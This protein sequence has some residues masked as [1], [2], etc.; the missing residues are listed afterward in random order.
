[1]PPK[2]RSWEEPWA[3]TVG[4]VSFQSGPPRLCGGGLCASAPDGSVLAY[5][6]GVANVVL[7]DVASGFVVSRFTCAPSIG[8]VRQLLWTRFGG[9]NDVVVVSDGKYIQTFRASLAGSDSSSDDDDFHMGESGVGAPCDAVC[10]L[11]QR[12]AC[13]AAIG[14][15]DFD[16]ARTSTLQLLVLVDSIDGAR[17]FSYDAKRHSLLPL[18]LR[19]TSSLSQSSNLFVCAE[20]KGVACAAHSNEAGVLAVGS[21]FAVTVAKLGYIQDVTTV[22]VSILRVCLLGAR[23][24]PLGIVSVCGISATRDA[25]RDASTTDSPVVELGGW[26]LFALPAE[27]TDRDE[28]IEGAKDGAGEDASALPG[29][30][31]GLLLG[32]LLLSNPRPSAVIAELS[33]S[34]AASGVAASFGDDD[35]DAKEDNLRSAMSVAALETCAAHGSLLSVPWNQVTGGG[36][37]AT[38]QAMVPLLGTLTST[39]VRLVCFSV[40][41]QEPAALG[42]KATAAVFH[43][44]A[45]V[46]LRACTD[47]VVSFEHQNVRGVPILAVSRARTSRSARA[48]DL[49]IGDG[50]RVVLFRHNGAYELLLST[51][52][53]PATNGATGCGTSLCLTLCGKAEWRLPVNTEDRS[54]SSS[55]TYLPWACVGASFLRSTSLKQRGSNVLDAVLAVLGGPMPPAPPKPASDAADKPLPGPSLVSLNTTVA[56]EACALFPISF[57]PVSQSAQG[58][59][60]RPEMRAASAMAVGARSTTTDGNPALS[61]ETKLW[62]ASIVNESQKALRRDLLETVEGLERRLMTRLGSLEQRL[63]EAVKGRPA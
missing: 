14:V 57:L 42:S 40:L 61:E 46:D 7:L 36:P 21:A 4:R 26:L 17:F 31:P 52:A 63:T 19:L 30:Q 37:R 27:A 48:E 8:T 24:S 47:E 23:V 25:T 53:R 51:C 6:D 34:D 20:L 45:P 10:L 43:G 58:V 44:P 56:L 18:S 12:H 15:S 5:C 41:R 3:R 22:S 11:E 35:N 9:A 54:S 62:L 33:S 28:A 13:V 29:S 60:H 59:A 55:S 38:L 1:M 2:P 39:R 32:G 50:Q 16:P 49:G